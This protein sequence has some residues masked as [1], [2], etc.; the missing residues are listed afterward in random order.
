MRPLRLADAKIAQT[1]M[2]EN[3]TG[4]YGFDTRQL[5]LERIAATRC[6]R[7]AFFE[8]SAAFTRQPHRNRRRSCFRCF[9]S[10]LVTAPPL[11]I[12][13]EASMNNS[14]TRAPGLFHTILPILGTFAALAALIGVARV[15]GAAMM[16]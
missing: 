5:Y 2:E 15:L 12:H 16:M 8:L 7:R 13:K 9:R 10:L 4:A 14:Q 6:N 11:P 3:V 1:A